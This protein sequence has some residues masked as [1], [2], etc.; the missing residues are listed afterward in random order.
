MSYF[1]RTTG[2]YSGQDI[3]DSQFWVRSTPFTQR[4]LVYI[5]YEGYAQAR[6]DG[7]A[8]L[9]PH[10]SFAVTASLHDL[11]FVPPVSVAWTMN[12]APITETGEVVHGWSGEM[13]THFNYTVTYT[14][15]QGRTSTAF[16]NFYTKLC[17]FPGCNDQ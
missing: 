15:A 10:T 5:T 6:V 3:A 11:S 7:P 8:N 14:D 9:M 13:G 2:R 4:T 12:G 17:D 16:T 1:A